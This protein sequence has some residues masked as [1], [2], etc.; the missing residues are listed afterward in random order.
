MKTSDDNKKTGWIVFAVIAG[1]GLLIAV[2][3]IANSSSSPRAFIGDR[4]DCDYNPDDV[5]SVRC[6]SGDSPGVVAS[7][8][9]A[10]TS[11]IDRRTADDGTVFLQYSDDIVAISAAAAG[12]VI[13][14]DD[15]DT[16]Y[17][18]HSTYV[19]VFGWTATRPSSSSGG[20]GSGGK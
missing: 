16:G 12:S 10:D 14:L 7:S 3:A 9:A 8:I 17:R 1:V 19:S 2:I 18:R 20:W 5:D 6:E 4:Y 15:Y 11:P 13:L